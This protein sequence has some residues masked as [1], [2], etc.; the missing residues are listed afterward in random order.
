MAKSAEKRGVEKSV[1]NFHGTK[2]K[3]L[4]WLPCSSMARTL[5][6]GLRSPKGQCA[7]AA[8]NVSCIVLSQV[9][10]L[11]ARSLSSYEVRALLLCH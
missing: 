3:S 7:A 6:S 1:L 5:G 10:N 11:Q 4:R 9:N 8:A 2:M